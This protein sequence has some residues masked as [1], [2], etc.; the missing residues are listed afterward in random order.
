LAFDEPQDDL[1]A[2]DGP[3]DVWLARKEAREKEQESHPLAIL[4]R[5]YMMAVQEWLK[6]AD[7]EL[8]AVARGLLEDVGKRFATDDV[9]EEAR[10]IAQRASRDGHRSAA[11]LLPKSEWAQRYADAFR[12]AWELSGGFITGITEYDPQEHHFA[13]PIKAALS[14]FPDLVFLIGKP[15]KS[16]QLRTQIQFYGSATKPVYLTSR[17]V[18]DPSARTANLDLNGAIVPAMPWALIKQPN[19]TPD[20]DDAGNADTTEPPETTSGSEAIHTESVGAERLPSLSEGIAR[21]PRKY[22]RFFAMGYDALNLAMN[23]Q[24]LSSGYSTLDGA[25]G[26][27]SLSYDGD[28][29]REP[30]WITFVNG[31]PTPLAIDYFPGP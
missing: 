19:G 14:G 15:L 29:Q 26:R 4:S 22:R 25:T 27:L 3:D 21:T 1:I 24:P 23:I 7:G 5:D 2:D 28:V 16:R 31:V 11:V 17:A 13:D 9:E 30:T 6:T 12:E 8:K 20:T 18:D 10:Q